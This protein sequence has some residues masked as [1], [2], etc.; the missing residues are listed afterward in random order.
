MAVVLKLSS[1]RTV[2]AS[3]QLA[4]PVFNVELSVNSAPHLRVTHRKPTAESE[5]AGD[6]VEVLQGGV[7]QICVNVICSDGGEG[8]RGFVAYPVRRICPWRSQ[9]AF[10]GSLVEIVQLEAGHKLY[11]CVEAGGLTTGSTWSF[12]RLA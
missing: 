8:C 3:T 9:T 6:T 11:L 7:Y 10:S 1:S 5:G 2:S 12:V 4:V